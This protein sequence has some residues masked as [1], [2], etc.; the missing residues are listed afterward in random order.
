MPQLSDKEIQRINE[1]LRKAV[2]TEKRNQVFLASLGPALVEMLRP[3][4]ETIGTAVG[5]IPNEVKRAIAEIKIDA[6]DVNVP[7]YTVNIPEIK[8]PKAE[9]SVSMPDI[10]TPEVTVNVPPIKVPK[11]DVTVNVPK[12]QNKDII[13][14]INELKD[15]IA[16]QK[17]TSVEIPEYTSKKPMPAL[18][19]DLKGNPMEFAGGGRGGGA[20]LLKSADGLIA[21]FGVGN[22]LNALRVVHATNVAQSVVVNSITGTLGASIIDSSG[23]QYSGSNPLQVNVSD[24]FGSTSVNSVFNADNRVR[25]SLETG[26]SGLTDS[27]LRASSVPVIQVSGNTDSVYV[28]GVATSIFAEIMNPDGRVKVE[29]PTGASGLTDTELRASAVPI[30]QVSGQR[31]STEVST[32]TAVTDITNSISAALVDSSGVQ[33]SG[34]NPLPTTATVSPFAT[35]YASDAVGSMN[36]IQLGGN[37]IA[38]D[39]GVTGAGVQR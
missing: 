1:A 18:L 31:W 7:T 32:V 12:N 27:E 36:V 25:V 39:S 30:M 29:L 34:T 15:S 14:A 9:V 16:D 33:Y 37:A 11:S 5:R 28:T 8:V 20:Q 6:P 10:P 2:D 26:G 35:Y 19:V 21:S 38:V 13:K 24:I 23:I 22:D 17:T 3:V 4:I